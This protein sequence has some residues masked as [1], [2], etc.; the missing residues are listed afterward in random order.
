MKLNFVLPEES[1][2]PLAGTH[3][4]AHTHTHTHTQGNVNLIVQP[5]RG[6]P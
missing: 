5:P 3:M 1:T 4:R 2:D 6:I